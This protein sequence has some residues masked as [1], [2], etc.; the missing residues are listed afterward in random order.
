MEVVVILVPIFVALILGAWAVLAPKPVD[1]KAE[2]AQLDEHIAWLE[3]RLAHAR[4]R[5]W[6]EQMM[7]NLMTQ[8]ATARRKQTRLGNG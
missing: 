1:V 8:L 5:N 7:E 4:E 6:D 2:R 3:D